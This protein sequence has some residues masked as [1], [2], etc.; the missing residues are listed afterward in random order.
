LVKKGRVSGKE[1]LRRS[2]V[3]YLLGEAEYLARRSRV[4]G[5]EEQSIWQV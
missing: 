3:Q 5:E 4:S 1:E 2:R